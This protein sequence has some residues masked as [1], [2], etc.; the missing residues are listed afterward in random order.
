[1]ISLLIPALLDSLL[2]VVKYNGYIWHPMNFLRPRCVSAVLI[3]H[4]SSLSHLSMRLG[5]K[6][7]ILQAEGYHKCPQNG[8][9]RMSEV[10]SAV[11]PGYKPSG[12]KSMHKEEPRFRNV[13]LFG[14]ETLNSILSLTMLLFFLFAFSSHAFCV[15]F[16]RQNRL[17]ATCSP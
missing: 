4:Q 9:W 17:H 12:K 14:T 2:F 3:T 11:T 7:Q 15:L 5:S 6:S 10:W 8:K 16:N 13:L 1:M